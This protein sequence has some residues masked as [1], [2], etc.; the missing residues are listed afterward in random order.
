MTS[1]K[2][3]PPLYNTWESMLQRCY[4]PKYSQFAAYGGRG[5]KVCRQWRHDYNRFAKD[6]GVR[7]PGMTLDRIDNDKDYTPENCRWATHKQ[8]QR[9][10]RR[11]RKVIIEG[12][13]YLVADLVEQSGRAANAIIRRAKAGLSLNDVL[14]MRFFQTPEYI[15]G[16]QIRAAQRRAKRPQ[17]LFC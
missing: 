10:H 6:M 7:P 13:T 9:N 8:Q 17:R 11:T 15:R 14:H 5:I 1:W 4:N 12:K 16:I 3:A 2:N